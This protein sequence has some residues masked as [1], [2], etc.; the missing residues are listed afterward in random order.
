MARCEWRQELVNENTGDVLIEMSHTMS[1]STL[2]P[3]DLIEFQITLSSSNSSLSWPRGLLRAAMLT[4]VVLSQLPSS[5]CV[6]GRVAGWSCG[7]G[8]A[9]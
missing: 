4:E 7:S 2:R 3:S 6:T 9:L 5:F 8:V 1:W